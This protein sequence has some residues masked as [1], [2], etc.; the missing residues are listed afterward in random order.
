MMLAQRITSG[1][2]AT[3]DLKQKVAVKQQPFT[4]FFG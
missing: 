2:I 4:M 3:V 1:I